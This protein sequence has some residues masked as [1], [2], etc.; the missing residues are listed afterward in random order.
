MLVYASKEWL[1]KFEVIVAD[2]ASPSMTTW[3]R[4]GL[5][6]KACELWSA[7]IRGPTEGQGAWLP[8]QQ[9]SLNGC[10]AG[11]GF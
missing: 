6:S 3:K 2:I 9:P 10:W 1:K 5:I 7:R 4:L 8:T 11:C